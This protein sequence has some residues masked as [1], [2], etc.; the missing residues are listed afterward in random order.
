MMTI[1]G[2]IVT[3]MIGV[4]NLLYRSELIRADNMVP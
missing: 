1:C 3:Y 2:V 4:M